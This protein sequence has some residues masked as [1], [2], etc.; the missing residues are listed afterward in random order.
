MNTDG[1]YQA[2][3]PA[4]KFDTVLAKIKL[5]QHFIPPRLVFFQFLKVVMVN[6]VIPIVNS[7]YLLS[8][9]VVHFI[10]YHFIILHNAAFILIQIVHWQ[11]LQIV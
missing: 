10:N 4:A 5:L 9:G 8:A 1:T 6:I 2:G 11:Y 7:C 3:S